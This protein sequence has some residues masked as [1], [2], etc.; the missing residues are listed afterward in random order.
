VYIKEKDSMECFWYQLTWVAVEKEPFNSTVAV[1][2]CC[3]SSGDYR[4]SSPERL[5]SLSFYFAVITT[6]LVVRI[7]KYLDRVTIPCIRLFVIVA[8]DHWDDC[9]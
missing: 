4:R 2:M 8:T 7:T 5:P 3:R 6:V 1:V 9:G